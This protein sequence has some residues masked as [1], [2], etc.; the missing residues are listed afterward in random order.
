MG[1]KVIIRNPRSTRPWQHVLEA[2]SGYLHL[3]ISLKK[4]QKIHGEVFNFG[5]QTSKELK[6]I[7]LVK[8]MRKKW[9]KVSWKTKSRKS[10]FFESN[11]L[12]LDSTKAKKLLNWNCILNFDETIF[13]VV[14]WYKTFYTSRKNM[15]KISLMQ[16]DRYQNLLNLRKKK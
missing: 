10:N 3:A 2:I 6:V 5:P 9:K 8:L 15:Q 12:K 13:M 4:N 1:E 16:I 14:D 11:L 7:N